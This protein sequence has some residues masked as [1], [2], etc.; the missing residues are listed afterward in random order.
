M[1]DDQK[2]RHDLQEIKLSALSILER[3]KSA[4]TAD[5]Q[6]AMMEYAALVDCFYQ[7]EEILA[8]HQYRAAK[9]DVEYFMRLVELAIQYAATS[10]QAQ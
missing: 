6:N 8:P 5:V 9:Q 4:D 2:H 7:V 10:D 1:E 3:I